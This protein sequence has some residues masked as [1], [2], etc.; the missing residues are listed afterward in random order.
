MFLILID[1]F[2]SV[3]VSTNFT[4][5]FF[6]FDNRVFVQDKI[7]VGRISKYEIKHQPIEEVGLIS[8]PFAQM[9][10]CVK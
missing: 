3:D 8:F 9:L 1:V 4:L 10:Q 6:L 7:C 5:V 2:P